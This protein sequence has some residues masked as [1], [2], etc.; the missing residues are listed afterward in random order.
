MTEP[1][2]PTAVSKLREL[3]RKDLGVEWPESALSSFAVAVQR[4]AQALGLASDDALADAAAGADSYALAMLAAELACVKA[5]GQE[6]PRELQ[7][8]QEV[9][10]APLLH[11]RPSSRPLLIWCAGCSTGEEAYAL[12]MICLE[13]DPSL[14]AD[15]VRILGTD[16]NPFRLE[17]ASRATYGPWTR[18]RKSPWPRQALLETLDDGGVRVAE[19]A[20]RLV[21]FAQ[22]NLLSGRP[23]AALDGL[24]ALACCRNV[25]PGLKPPDRRRALATLARSLEARGWLALGD[26]ERLSERDGWEV[27][28]QPG[29]PL[30]RRRLCRAPTPR[31]PAE[32]RRPA[33]P[34]FATLRSEVRGGPAALEAMAELEGAIALEQR[35]DTAGAQEALHRALELD[36]QL[37]LAHVLTAGLHER[38]GSAY[39]ARRHYRR[40]LCLLEGRAACAIVPQGNGVTVSFLRE[41]AARRLARLTDADP[42]GVAAGD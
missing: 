3:V 41:H 14:T 42:G 9:I 30:H 12:A 37:V 39:E 18:H 40:V 35:G 21:S 36:P 25:L 1:C 29:G 5:L 33:A 24:V 22:H 32:R 13:V 20:R 11:S 27:L 31:R 26:G 15:R 28:E 4:A 34:E 19:P 17:Q 8:L 2:W 38:L 23:P 7:T 10:L 6:E 16:V